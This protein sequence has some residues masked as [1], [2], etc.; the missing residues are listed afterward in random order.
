M[1]GTAPAIQILR[2]NRDKTA[3]EIV[4]ALYGGVREY[5]G[6]DKPHDDITLVVVKVGPQP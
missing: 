1:W 3:S 4:D 5:L 2:E 6:P